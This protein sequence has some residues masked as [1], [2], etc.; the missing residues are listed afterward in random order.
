MKKL[1]IALA[2]LG[3][4]LRVWL[5]AQ[6]WFSSIL[7]PAIPRNL[8]WWLRAAYL[9]P[10]D[11]LDRLRSD[12][13][14]AAPPRAHN[15]SGAAI[16]L[17]ANGAGLIAAL[18][19]VAGLTPASRVLDVGCGMG[20]LAM[21]M[22]G[23][24][25]PTGAYEGLDIVPD[26][27]RWCREHVA[28]PYGNVHFTLSDVRNDEYNP[29]GSIA[30]VDY[31]F[32]FEDASFD[33]V[34]LVSVF[35]HMLPPELGHYL[36]E[37]ARVLALGGRCF[38]TYYLLTPEARDRMANHRS[39]LRFK[40]DFGSHAVVSTKMPELSVGY[41]DRYLDEVYARHGLAGERYPGYWCGQPSKWSPASGTGE[42]DV[43]VAR[44]LDVPTL[45]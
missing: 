6:H 12:D 44:K 17:Q 28:A 32:P 36:D 26:G 20:R 2:A 38:A 8:R 4:R 18:E 11:A 9:A 35:T 25:G 3:E 23:Y 7:L 13:S 43:L 10:I 5:I 37:I 19:E 24:L 15:F 22:A 16:D 41:H 45:V 33:V 34:V 39:A 31:R 14:V 40:H 1:L 27:I 30:A 21:A 29:G 42:Q